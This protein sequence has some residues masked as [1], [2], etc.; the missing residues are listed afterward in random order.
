[1]ENPR[2]FK[3]LGQNVPEVLAEFRKLVETRTI[4]DTSQLSLDPSA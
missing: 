4:G 2:V 1:L 3:Y